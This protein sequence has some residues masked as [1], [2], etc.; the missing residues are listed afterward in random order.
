MSIA[1]SACMHMASQSQDW[2]TYLQLCDWQ[3][4][5]T[6]RRQSCISCS[7]M[8][9]S[10]MSTWKLELQPDLTWWDLFSASFGKRGQKARSGIASHTG[11]GAQ[12][13]WAIAHEVPRVSRSQAMFCLPYNGQ[14]PVQ[15]DGMLGLHIRIEIDDLKNNL[16]YPFALQYQLSWSKN[17]Y[18]ERSVPYQILL[19]LANHRYAPCLAW[20]F[21]WSSG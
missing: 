10:G 2:K 20:G 17:V 3:H 21:T 6:T 1:T 19:G 14:V 8:A 18:E 7:I 4:W 13:I 5:N 16:Q 15:H 11:D 12:Q 9:D